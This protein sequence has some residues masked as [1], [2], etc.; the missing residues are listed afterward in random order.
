MGDSKSKK[1]M[2]GERH[3]KYLQHSPLTEFYPL[4][5]PTAF[6]DQTTDIQEVILFLDALEIMFE[7]HISL[8]HV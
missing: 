6:R 3:E 1:S 8:L 4:F 2:E 7:D 5:P